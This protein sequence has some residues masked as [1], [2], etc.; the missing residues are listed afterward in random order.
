MTQGTPSFKASRKLVWFVIISVVG[1]MVLSMF[2]IGKDAAMVLTTGIPSLAGLVA[3]WTH[4]TN[5][6]ETERSKMNK[7]K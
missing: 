7:E 4:V 5:K 1:L 3:S 6:T 2:T